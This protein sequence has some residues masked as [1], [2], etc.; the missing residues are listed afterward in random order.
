MCGILFYKV[1][2]SL[3]TKKRMR[4]LARNTEDPTTLRCTTTER[5]CSGFIDCP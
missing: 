2:R 4:T 5:S 3:N 1:I